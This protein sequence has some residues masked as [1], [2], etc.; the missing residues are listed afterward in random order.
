MTWLGIAVLPPGQEQL[1]PPPSPLLSPGMSK[2]DL[3]L[4][5]PLLTICINPQ[6]R[7]AV[8]LPVGWV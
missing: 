5:I 2:Y 7:K 8:A 1:T 6:A 4:T 3:S